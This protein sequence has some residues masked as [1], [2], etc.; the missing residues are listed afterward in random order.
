MAV[1]VAVRRERPAWMN[2]RTAFGLL[3]FLLSLLS[4][5]HLLEGT[6]RGARLWAAA[7]DL[8]AGVPLRDS[9]LVAVTS[10]LGGAQLSVYLGANADLVGAQLT[11]PAS[12]GE[13]LAARFVAPSGSRASEQA[14]TVPVTADHAVGGELA[15][16]DRVDVYATLTGG[17]GSGRTSL[18]VGSAQILALVTS[19]DLMSDG[20]SLTGLTLQ[21]DP[22]EAP[23]LAF[24][25]RTADIDVVRVNGE[26]PATRRGAVSE[27][28]L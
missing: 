13:L 19:G 2:L 24:A 5:W 10:D 25:V 9:D 21:V 17:R 18:V 15:P 23:R 27:A 8:P 6:E 12:E 22:D 7:A 28:D 3:L 26:V 20:R 11:R 4:G 1:S 16:G 14:M